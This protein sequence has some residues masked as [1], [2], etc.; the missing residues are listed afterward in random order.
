MSILMPRKRN[1]HDTLVAEL[2]LAGWQVQ[3]HGADDVHVLLLRTCATVYTSTPAVLSAFG[4][5]KHAIP[6]LLRSL[7][8]H[9][10]KFATAILSTRRELE[11]DPGQVCVIPP[12]R[13]LLQDPP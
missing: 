1:Q 10:V 9:A 5:P 3:T 4:L 8:L 11:R 6:P 7:H 13:T 12:P 2:R